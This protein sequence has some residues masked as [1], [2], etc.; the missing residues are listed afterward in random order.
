VLAPDSSLA[1]GPLGGGA[2]PPGAPFSFF[3]NHPPNPLAAG[4]GAG[5]AAASAVREA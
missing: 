1:D 2:G 5:A 3:L 4:T